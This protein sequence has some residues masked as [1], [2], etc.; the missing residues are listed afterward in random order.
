MMGS[1]LPFD[2][3]DGDHYPEGK[4][5]LLSAGEEPSSDS[6]EVVFDQS[7]VRS[8]VRSEVGSEDK[9]TSVDADPQD[10]MVTVNLSEDEPGKFLSLS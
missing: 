8:E 10:E 1:D 4:L 7:V 6:E 9:T 5:P 2:G 3:E